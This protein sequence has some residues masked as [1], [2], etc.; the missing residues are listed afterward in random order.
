MKK[1]IFVQ[2]PILKSHKLKKELN[3]N[4]YYKAEYFQPSG[5]F[6]I[7][8]MEE[9]CRHHIKEGKTNFISSSGGNAG[10]SMAYVGKELG[11]N[12]KVIVPETTAQTMINKIKYLGTDV[13]VQGNVWDE[14]HKY[15]LKLAEETNAVI[16]SPF[17]DP[18]LWKGHST[19][20]DECA[21]EIEQPDV[22]VVSVGGGG[23]L[24]GIFEGLKRNGWQN[25]LVI[26]T[27]TKGAASF[28]K[29]YEAGKLIELDNIDSIAT[30]LGA[31]KVTE[32]SLKYAEDFNV[33]PFKMSDKDAVNSSLI[34]LEEY[35]VLVEPACGAAL[36]VPYYH[37]EL[38]KDAENVLVIVCGGVNTDIRKYLEI[39]ST[40]NN[41][42]S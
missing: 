27:E 1:Q 22:V 6:K 28:Y 26:T 2:T 21:N 9:L 8:G 16:V 15:A 3:K 36:S 14:A 4:I 39:S 42:A 31:L 32:Q 40:K 13:E 37:S 5:S 23:L 30:S 19:I 35:N 12:V 18:L 41:F 25:T 33:L 11:V 10:Y 34:F 29:S 17:D 20:I 38:I 24:C 7:R